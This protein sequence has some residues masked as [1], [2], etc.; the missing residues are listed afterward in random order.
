MH[1]YLINICFADSES[2]GNATSENRV[3]LRRRGPLARGSLAALS[4]KRE[5]LLVS[6]S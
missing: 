3:E 2:S 5:L 4:A 1:N 6:R